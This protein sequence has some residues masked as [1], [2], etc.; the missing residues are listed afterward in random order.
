MEVSFSRCIQRLPPWG[1][2][3][4]S[5][6]TC[7]DLAFSVWHRRGGVSLN[8][9]LQYPLRS[10]FSTSRPTL[11]GGEQEGRKQDDGRCPNSRVRMH[12]D[13][14]VQ[15]RQGGADGSRSTMISSCVSRPKKSVTTTK[16]LKSLPVFPPGSPPVGDTPVETSEAE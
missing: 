8:A 11:A 9:I 12:C 7:T 5:R 4:L 14:R 2:V 1:W 13:S 16:R 10:A 15:M 6:P 3:L